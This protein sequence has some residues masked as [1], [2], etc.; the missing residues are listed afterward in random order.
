MAMTDLF[1]PVI[2]TQCAQPAAA[3]TIGSSIESENS[4][5]LSLIGVETR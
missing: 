5:G 3:F 1:I 2:E 4:S